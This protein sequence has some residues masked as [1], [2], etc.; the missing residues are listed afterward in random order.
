MPARDH[1]GV[2]DMLMKLGADASL[3]NARGRTASEFALQ[4]GNR[5]RAS[6][7]EKRGNLQKRRRGGAAQGGGGSGSAVGSIGGLAASETSEKDR[8]AAEAAEAAAQTLVSQEGGSG[9]DGGGDGTLPKTQGN[10]KGNKKKKAQQ[11]SPSSA[12]TPDAASATVAHG[13]DKE[14]AEGY[15]EVRDQLKVAY[16]KVNDDDDNHDIVMRDLNCREYRNAI[17]HEQW[18][19]PMIDGGS[20]LRRACILREFGKASWLSEEL[21]I[22]FD[23]ES[24]QHWAAN[25]DEAELAFLLASSTHPLL[26]ACFIDAGTS[27]IGT[28]HHNGDEVTALRRMCGAD[29]GPQGQPQLIQ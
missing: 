17:Q 6:L 21:K 9:G 1:D 5:S 4:A 2:V 14:D 15:D 22:A 29:A 19:K 11:K 12:T 16:D 18:D 10:K 23:S 8:L 28:I 3:K 25:S 7:L 27:V 26:A 20:V 24:D 13:A